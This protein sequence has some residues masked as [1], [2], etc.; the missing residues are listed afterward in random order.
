MR[1]SVIESVGQPGQYEGLTAFQIWVV[2]NLNECLDD[3]NGNTES[4]TGWFAL[5]GRFI[6][7]RNEQGF[8][9]VERFA[10]RTLAKLAFD[11]MEDQYA[12]WAREGDSPE[13]PW[14]L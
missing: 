7:H 3:C 13:D 8:W 6:V 12:M 4:P 5:C 14:P 9:S 1:A 10:S 11:A 2:E